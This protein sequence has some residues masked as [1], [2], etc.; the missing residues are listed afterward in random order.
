M[1]SPAVWQRPDPLRILV[2]ASASLLSTPQ[3]SSVMPKILDLA[4]G[5]IQAEAYAVWRAQDGRTWKILAAK[6]LS[7]NYTSQILESRTQPGMGPT[8]IVVEDLLAHPFYE[9]R[10]EF[11]DS[12]GIRSLLV[13]PLLIGAKPEGTITFYWKRTHH[14]SIEDLDY[15]VALA[16]LAAAAINTA[17]LYEARVLQEK[18]S[19]FLGEASSLLASSLDY[20]ETLKQ[21]ARLAVPSVADWCSVRIVENDALAR[22]AVAHSD[23]EKLALADEFS[24][25]FPDD[26]RPDRGL[27]RV[28]A[29]G[30][31][32]IYPHVTE[33]MLIA[34]ARDP[35][36]LAMLRQLGITSVL[37][38]PLNARGRT[39]GAITMIAAESGR[40]FG[41]DDLQLAD[42][43]ARRA[44][45]AVDNARLHRALR[46]SEAQFRSLVE[47]SPISTVV[48][49][50]E[51]HPLESNP[52]FERLFGA[53]LS[54]APT[55]YTVF[56]DPQ[57]HASG[58]IPL[59][60]RAFRGE[61]V[62]LPALRYDTTL[63]STTGKGN[64]FWAE[65]VLY[66]VR[67]ATGKLSRVVMLQTDVS[68]KI[69]A[70]KKRLA[71]EASLRRTE[72]LA[73]AGRLAAT[74]AHEI[75]NPLE[76]I[77]NILFILR[78]DS[79]IPKE[80]EEYLV[81]ADIEL[82]R[83]AHIAR[84]TLGF[85]RE[86][87]LPE[88]ADVNL[89]VED[90][91]SIYRKRFEAREIS[92][93][94]AL[95]SETKAYIMVGEIKQV[96]ANL[97]SNAID[98]C[99]ERGEIAVRVLSNGT[100]IRIEV[101]DDGHGIDADHLPH[102]FEPFFSTKKDVGTGL[103]LWV[104]KEIVDRHRGRIE[105]ETRPMRQQGTLFRVTLPLHKD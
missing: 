64:T 88:W 28:L 14:T 46:E 25:R 55:G 34:G 54:D 65:A 4:A 32:E 20:D 71:T 81:T 52:A 19:R 103:G 39:L 91:L 93:S 12:E 60:E 1:P 75:N 10:R 101:E 27:G 58:V 76:A 8:P 30:C 48:F 82:R 69:E 66:P 80:F 99:S 92:L 16:N 63:T 31:S 45:V 95:G 84:Q 57:L 38:V 2:E 33:E 79:R 9:S 15:A 7:D 59:L 72:K 67:D 98:A 23:P 22:T 90:I 74:V 18:R 37:I 24:K 49:D 73:T 29:T 44:A 68:E 85:Y 104:S 50:A 41:E 62:M 61:E 11:Y 51:G 70:E 5:V 86:N 56:N 94:R 36:H 89:L 105:V 35:E 21:V 96:I 97:V 17:E 53:T 13:V 43:L 87:V 40:H 102:I 42:D 26:L 77:T 6:G 47:Q 100:Q 3:L 78:S 83:V